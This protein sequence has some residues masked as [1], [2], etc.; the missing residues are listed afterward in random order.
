M[1]KFWPDSTTD[2]GVIC[3]AASEK[4]MDNILNTLAPSCL[5][6]SSSLLQVPMTSMKFRMSSKFGQIRPWTAELAALGV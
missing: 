4:S 2:Y 3:P 5:I 6:V 1:F